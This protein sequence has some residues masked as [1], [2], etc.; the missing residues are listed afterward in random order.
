MS[1]ALQSGKTNKATG[2][3]VLI[4]R[5]LLWFRLGPVIPFYI[6]HGRLNRALTLR[7]YFC[8]LE[9]IPASGALMDGYPTFRE[10]EALQNG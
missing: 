5:Y 1:T 8:P 6:L 4:S 9:A 3:F 2:V 7:W 10:C